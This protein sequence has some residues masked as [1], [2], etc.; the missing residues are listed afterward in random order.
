LPIPIYI[1][2]S[3]YEN[4]DDDEDDQDHLKSTAE[5]LIIDLLSLSSSCKIFKL[6]KSKS[7]KK[8]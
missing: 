2:W 8:C 4:D 6:L 1:V 7:G 3:T 5:L